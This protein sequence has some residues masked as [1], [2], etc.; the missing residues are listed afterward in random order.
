M[1]V[2]DLYRSL[3]F[4]VSMLELPMLGQPD[5]NTA[6]L[7][8]SGTHLIISAKPTWSPAPPVRGETRIVLLMDD[9]GYTV[10][11][12][13]GKGVQFPE[14]PRRAGD[15]TFAVLVDPDGNRLTLMGK[16]E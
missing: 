5:A 16:E 11:M 9:V 3:D 1:G 2:G 14:P 4:Y 10:D 7:F 6:V 8:N 12:L 13:Q 15:L